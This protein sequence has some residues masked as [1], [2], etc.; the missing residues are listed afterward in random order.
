[1]ML[2][3]YYNFSM[4]PAT[5]VGPVGGVSTMVMA[6]SSTLS[7]ATLS[8]S[9]ASTSS[10][11][12]YHSASRFSG[13]IS[14]EELSLEQKI[15]RLRKLFN[16]GP[17]V[18][19]AAV[20]LRVQLKLT[21][22]RGVS[23]SASSN[24]TTTDPLASKPVENITYMQAFFDSPVALAVVRPDGTIVTINQRWTDLT[25][26]DTQDCGNGYSLQSAMDFPSLTVIYTVLESFSASE[27][28]KHWAN[29]LTM[30]KKKTHEKIPVQL[31]LTVIQDHSSPSSSSSQAP[32]VAD[33]EE[34]N[35]TNRQVYRPLLCSVIYNTWQG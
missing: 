25:G 2:D 12:R 11:F 4:A 7:S 15:E 28:Q 24:V 17:E 19:P 26:I 3:H 31:T 5:V 34:V 20:L 18:E 35:N 6:S 30:V 1:M 32:Q 13:N 22:M 29:Q 8:S 21:Q 23:T 14:S 27:E 16:I 10:A 33:A 9:S